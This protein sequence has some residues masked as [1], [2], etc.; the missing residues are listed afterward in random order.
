MGRLDGKVAHRHRRGPRPGRRRRR[1]CSARG[2]GRGRDHRHPRDEGEAVADD[3][4]ATFL[5]HD[6]RS[7]EEWAAVVDATVEQHGRIDV[8]VN[9]AG[10]FRREAWSTP[11]SRRT[12]G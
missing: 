7:E 5:P 11:T 1:R 12:A 4:G 3:I 9:N 2:G 10:I 8:L 6:V